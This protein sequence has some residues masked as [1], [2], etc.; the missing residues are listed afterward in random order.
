MNGYHSYYPSGNNTSIMLQNV[1]TG[2]IIQG[3]DILSWNAMTI[4]DDKVWHDDAKCFD[5]KTGKDEKI[6]SYNY[7][8]VIAKYNDTYIF[9]GEDDKGKTIFEKIPQNTSS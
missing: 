4:I 7:G 2:E 5:I 9:M 8:Q 3:P 1:T 6:S